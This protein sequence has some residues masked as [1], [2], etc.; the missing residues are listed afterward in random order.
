M[1]CPWGPQITAPGLEG[2]EAGWLPLT[3]ALSPVHPQR[4]RR[5]ANGPCFPPQGKE[6]VLCARAPQPDGHGHSSHAMP[7]G[8]LCGLP[9]SPPATLASGG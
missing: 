5:L 6:T 8:R 7:E 4:Q 3:F 2:Q 1:G 9:H